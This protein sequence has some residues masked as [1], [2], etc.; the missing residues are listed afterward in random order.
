MVVGDSAS[1]GKKASSR[2]P[3]RLPRPRGR[4]DND[5]LTHVT[6]GRTGDCPGPRKE[7]TEG[8]NVTQGARA[9][10]PACAIE[11]PGALGAA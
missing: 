6:K 1:S 9:G 3:L 11:S 5:D 7:T 8:R 2:R 4:A 10:A